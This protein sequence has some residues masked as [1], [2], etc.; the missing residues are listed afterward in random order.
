[1]SDE[2]KRTHYTRQS[3]SLPRLLFTHGRYVEPLSDVRTKIGKGRVLARLGLGG[4]DK[5]F[6]NIL[7]NAR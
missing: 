7:T 2:A 4:C 6:F 1:M 3:Q 5:A